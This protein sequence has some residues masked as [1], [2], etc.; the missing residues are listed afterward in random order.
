M[1]SLYQLAVPDVS[2]AFCTSE[3]GIKG[4]G[5][6]SQHSQAIHYPEAQ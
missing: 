6:Q 4:F 3:Y 1:S 5:E 2:Y